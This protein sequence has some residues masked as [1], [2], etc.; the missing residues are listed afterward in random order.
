MKVRTY[1]DP[2]EP[3]VLLAMRPI[4]DFVRVQAVGDNGAPLTGGNIVDI[5]P[6]GITRW[7]NVNPDLG[8]PLDEYGAVKIGTTT[9]TALITALKPFVAYLKDREQ[10]LPGKPDSDTVVSLGFGPARLT[11]GDLRAL[12]KLYV[13]PQ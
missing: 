5:G 1:G 3:E 4:S 7:G 8:L 2:R 9:E 10:H 11:V 6:G 13:E 12:A